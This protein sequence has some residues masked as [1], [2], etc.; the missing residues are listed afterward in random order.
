VRL[1]DDYTPEPRAVE[2]IEIENVIGNNDEKLIPLRLDLIAHFRDE[3]G[4]THAVIFRPE[5][6]DK[7]KN[8]EFPKEIAWTKV[9]E[10]STGK[11]MP[12]VLL[13]KINPDIQPWVFSG[14]DGKIYKLKWN[15]NVES[16]D[17]DADW[18]EA[19]LRAFSEGNFESDINEF[20]CDTKCQCRVPCPHWMG[21]IE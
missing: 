13:R 5:S 11:K 7:P 2:F 19:R 20:F 1:A 17:E 18:A 4:Q 3:N 12:F 21:A 14:E 8:G 9:K 15:R 6:L 10:N 16:M